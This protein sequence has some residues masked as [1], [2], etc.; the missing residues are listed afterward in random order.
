[1]VEET[2]AAIRTLEL[3]IRS[4]VDA[5]SEFALSPSGKSHATAETKAPQR[6]APSTHRTASSAEPR[7]RGGAATARK[8]HVEPDQQSW[9][10]F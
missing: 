1:M 5:V 4:V 9:E 8:V 6:S 10:E 7:N 3:E 2:T